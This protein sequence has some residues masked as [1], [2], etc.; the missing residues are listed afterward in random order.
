MVARDIVLAELTG[1]HVHI[2]HVSTAGAVR[3]VRDAKARGV[4]VTAE[5]TPHHLL[6]TDE[7]V[8]ELRPQ[9]QDGAA[10][11]DAS[12]TSRRCSRRSP[13]APSTASPPTTRPTRSPRRKASS[14]R[15]PTGSWGSRRRSPLLLDRLVRRGRARP[16]DPGRAAHR[17]TGAAAR[18]CPA[19]ASPRAPPPT[20]RSSTSSGR[21]RSTRRA[22]ARAAGTRPS[23]AGRASGA[24][25]M[26]IVGGASDHG[27]DG[28]ARLPRARRRP[29]LSRARPAA[30]RAKAPARSC[31]TPR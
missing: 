24:P 23:A 9:H 8:R 13:T 31:S 26:T 14:T 25:W 5:V 29:R 16:A 19:A 21:G 27:H 12:A 22:S 17:G 11:A 30:P 10:A 3:L 2:A 1:A 20:S 28:A 15:R 4:A 18:T 7:A 6:L